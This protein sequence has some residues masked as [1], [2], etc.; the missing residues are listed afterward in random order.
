[1]V[2]RFSWC[3]AK[4]RSQERPIYIKH[5]DALRNGA[6]IRATATA[7]SIF[8]ASRASRKARR[9][10]R[11][12]TVFANDFRG[13]HDRAQ[14]QHRYAKVRPTECARS[15]VRQVVNTFLDML[16]RDIG[17]NPVMAIGVSNRDDFGPQKPYAAER[18]KG[19][20]SIPPMDRGHDFGHLDYRR[21]GQP[22]TRRR[23]DGSPTHVGNPVVR[24]IDANGVYSK[25]SHICL[26]HSVNGIA[27][28]CA[29]SF[30]DSPANFLAGS[31]ATATATRLER[32]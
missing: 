18:K 9:L 32:D 29:A 27:P 17:V 31:S 19:P 23:V 7:S 16:A 11:Q 5:G 26:H 15:N 14:R 25:R 22:V 13:H 30:S 6:I 4:R 1:L 3:F 2:F 21:R 10:A 20:N 24:R 8:S 12:F 28:L